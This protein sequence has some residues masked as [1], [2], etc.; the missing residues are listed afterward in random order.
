LR[1]LSAALK[2][3]CPKRRIYMK[4]VKC[5]CLVVLMGWAFA[6]KASNTCDT[7]LTF[8]SG[9]TAMNVCISN[10]G[11]IVK[12]ESPAGFDQIGPSTTF[13]DGYAICSGNL[14]TFANVSQGYNPGDVSAEAGFGPA[15]VI[16]PGGANTLPLTIIR[17]ST[18][19]N[20]QLTQ[21]FAR[22]TLHRTVTITMKIKRLL[23]GDC[24][25]SGCPPVRLQRAFEGDVDN[26]TVA[27]ARF[28]RTADSVF[29]WIDT[30]GGFNGTTGHG[31]HLTNVANGGATPITTVYTVSDYGAYADQACIVYSGEVATPT[32]P[33]V[34]D[35]T[36]LVGRLMYFFGNIPLNH[37]Q[38]V[39]VVYERF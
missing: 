21:S 36:T 31:L 25:A 34:T 23:N 33:T 5:F 1:S 4:I 11:N 10:E 12:F 28:G 38:T 3:N 14:P 29:E 18:S 7:L 32:D 15:T 20:Y 13:R 27:N 6:A 16:Q 9:A 24:T 35:A 17:N 26:N 22:D 8:G 39:K 37:S 2:K 30:T 19:G